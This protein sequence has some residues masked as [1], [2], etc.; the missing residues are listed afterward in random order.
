MIPKSDGTM[1]NLYAEWKTLAGWKKPINTIGALTVVNIIW[2]YLTFITDATVLNLTLYLV[3]F[4]YIGNSFKSLPDVKNYFGW[5]KKSTTEEEEEEQGTM[6][7]SEISFMIEGTKTY[8]SILREFRAN[9]PGLFCGFF[10]A[11]FFMMFSTF[12]PYCSLLPCFFLALNGCLLLPLALIKLKEQQPGVL[13][14]LDKLKNMMLVIAKDFLVKGFEKMNKCPLPENAKACMGAR[15][16]TISKVLQV[17][18][19]KV[20]TL[21]TKHR[22]ETV[23]TED[24]KKDQEQ[25]SP[26]ETA[27]PELKD[28][29]ANL[30]QTTS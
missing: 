7:M 12:A 29:N 14:A 21:I 25:I 30:E 1:D 26:K 5:E 22:S 6:S 24:P 19:T 17:Y 28:V 23:T 9:T 2:L 10:S 13:D 15:L 4:L 18:Y 16:S 11:F 27:H 8:F 20:A 3:L